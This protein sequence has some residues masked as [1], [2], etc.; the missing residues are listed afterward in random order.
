MQANKLP[1][2]ERRKN[3]KMDVG[4][5]HILK[6]LSVAQIKRKVVPPF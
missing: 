4:I 6:H 1:K 2:Y 5:F 3:T